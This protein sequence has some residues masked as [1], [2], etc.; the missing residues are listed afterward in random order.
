MVVLVAAG[1]AVAVAV[2]VVVVTASLV[3]ACVGV[4][5]GSPFFCLSV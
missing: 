3:S 2:A 1:V 5:L 4:L